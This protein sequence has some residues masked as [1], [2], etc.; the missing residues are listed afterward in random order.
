MTKK[1]VVNL[2]ACEEVEMVALTQRVAKAPDKSNER[3]FS[4]WRMQVNT[5]LK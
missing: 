1:Y 4:F 3:T 5:I 2:D